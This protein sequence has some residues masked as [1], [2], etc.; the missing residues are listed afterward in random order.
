MPYRS[1]ANKLENKAKAKNLYVECGSLP[2]RICLSASIRYDQNKNDS[3]S[4][5][6]DQYCVF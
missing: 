5:I 1:K 2:R 3:G 6:C 4:T